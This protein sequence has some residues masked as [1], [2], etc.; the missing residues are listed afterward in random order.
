[1]QETATFQHFLPER[2]QLSHAKY[3]SLLIPR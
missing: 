2:Q 3:L 1:M